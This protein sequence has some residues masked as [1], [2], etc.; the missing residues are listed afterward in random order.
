MNLPARTRYSPLCLGDTDEL[1][2]A[3]YL[4]QVFEFIGEMPT[5]DDFILDLHTGL[6]GPPP[7]VD[8][9]WHHF[10]VRLASTDQLIGRLEATVHDGLAEVGYLFSPSVWGQGH[11]TQGLHWLHQHLR[12]LGFMG[13]TWATVHPH[14]VRS[15][16]VVQRCGYLQ[17][18][19]QCLPLLHSYDA[20]DLVFRRGVD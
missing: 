18:P 12:E 6:A 20:G 16:A 13:D 15:K 17:V 3:L 7:G 4:P 19:N 9:Q 14:N 1:M 10:A 8:E 2:A 11:A 5:R